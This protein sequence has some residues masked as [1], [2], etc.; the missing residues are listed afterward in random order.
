MNNTQS[1]RSAGYTS[2]ILTRNIRIVNPNQN[3]NRNDKRR[4]KQVT[5]FRTG[6]GNN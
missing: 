5:G 6:K 4:S 2:T 1:G 3:R